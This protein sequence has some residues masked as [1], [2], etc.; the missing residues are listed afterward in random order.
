MV[1]PVIFSGP[2]NGTMVF[3]NMGVIKAPTDTA[4]LDAYQWIKFQYIERLIV[5]G[6]GSF[7]GQGPSAWSYNQCSKS[8]QCKTLPI[9]SF[10]SV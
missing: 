4:S 1:K 9:V 2:C 10:L 3:V 6:R 7:D 8:A 5:T